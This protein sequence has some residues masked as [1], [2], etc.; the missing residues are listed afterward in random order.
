MCAQAYDPLDRLAYHVG[1][2]AG[3]LWSRLVTGQTVVVTDAQLYH[4]FVSSSVFAFA[5]AAY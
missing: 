2:R 3:P 4:V 1:R 5:Y